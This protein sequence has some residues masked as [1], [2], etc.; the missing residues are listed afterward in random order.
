MPPLPTGAPTTGNAG[1]I[2]WALIGSAVLLF[3]VFGLLKFL[4]PSGKDRLAHKTKDESEAVAILRS[5]VEDMKL[6]VGSLRE[7]VETLRR[8]READRDARHDLKNQMQTVLMWCETYYGL[9]MEIKSEWKEMPAHLVARLDG[10]KKPS[11]IFR[12]EKKDA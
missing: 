2:Y 8:E 1:L 6:E 4:Y 10:M 11:E 7:E 9:M 5:Q 12:R 3:V